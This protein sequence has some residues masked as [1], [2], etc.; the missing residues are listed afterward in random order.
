MQCV[1]IAEN[2]GSREWYSHRRRRRC[3]PSRHRLKL[4]WAPRPLRSNSWNGDRLKV[5]RA[6]VHQ[7]AFNLVRRVG[8]SGYTGGERL[9]PNPSQLGRSLALPLEPLAGSFHSAARPDKPDNVCREGRSKRGE[10]DGMTV[11][12]WRSLVRSRT[13]PVRRLPADSFPKAGMSRP[14]SDLHRHCQRV[15]RA[16]NTLPDNP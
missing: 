16:A 7:L 11:A 3:C 10:D 5:K 6:V 15:P 2:E 13:L 1:E 12:S 4:R 9:L 14:G 8:N